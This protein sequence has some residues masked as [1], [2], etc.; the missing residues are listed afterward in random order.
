M[1]ENVSL[2]LE[3]FDISSGVMCKNAKY[4]SQKQISQ[5]FFLPLSLFFVD[6]FSL[7]E[8]SSTCAAEGA[9][10]PPKM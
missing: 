10:Y 6:T 5:G 3:N 1:E 7:V 2:H 4:E 9:V 8:D